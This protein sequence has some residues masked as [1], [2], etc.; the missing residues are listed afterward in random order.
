VAQRH[1][2]RRDTNPSAPH[3]GNAFAPPGATHAIPRGVP[4]TESA[5][6]TVS[7]SP[8]NRQCGQVTLFGLLSQWSK[9]KAATASGAGIRRS[10][11]CHQVF[12]SA[13]QASRSTSA[14]SPFGVMEHKSQ[15]YTD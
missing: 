10:E 9:V 13:N 8:H 14:G 2:L 3:S 12:S 7:T 4:T 11:I 5:L 1:A 6:R 15:H